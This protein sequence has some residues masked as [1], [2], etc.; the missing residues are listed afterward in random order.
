M[1][2]AKSA[3]AILLA[4]LMAFGVFAVCAFADGEEG[5]T[6]ATVV[7]TEE[8]TEEEE[9]LSFLEQI[10][11]FLKNLFNFENFNLEGLG[12]FFGKIG[13]SF[14]GIFDSIKDFFSFG[15]LQW[16]QRLTGIFFNFDLLIRIFIP[17]GYLG[18]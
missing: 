1:K 17:D 14:S 10:L 16:L 11:D 5:E 7:A 12:D 18:A 15:L 8:T 3:L 9:E 6:E 13:E 2:L 4:A